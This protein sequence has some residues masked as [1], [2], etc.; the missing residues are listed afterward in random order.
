MKLMIVIFAGL[1]F[2]SCM[3]VGMMGTGDDHHVGAGHEMT[4]D[5]VLEKEVVMGEMRATAVFPPLELGTD[6]VLTLRLMDARTGAPI[7]GAQVYFHVQHV[8][9][10]NQHDAAA[11][12]PSQMKEQ[13]HDGDTNQ[14]VPESTTPGVYTIPFG[15]SHAGEYT[16]IFTVTAIGDRMLEP[17]MRLEA[18][19]TVS[20][21]S[22]EHHASM[23]GGSNTTTFLI[24]G[25]VVMGAMMVVMLVA[26]GHTH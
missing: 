21:E 4:S 26:L 8:H 18:I 15:S 17:E 11:E 23:M 13:E 24:I 14:E 1:I 19:R 3:H 16:L 10:V 5:S 12:S 2:S 25:G 20:G 22:N 9:H 6:A 7:S